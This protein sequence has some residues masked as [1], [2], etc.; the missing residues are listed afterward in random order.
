MEQKVQIESTA[1]GSHTLFVPSLNEHYHS[2]NG[3]KQE[4]E[5]IYINTGLLHSTKEKL[6]LLEIGFG[7]GL[8]AY[9]TLLIT[10]QT[11]KDINYIS[12]E[13]YPLSIDIVKGLNYVENSDSKCKSLYLKLHESEWNCKNEIT[14][15]F[16]LTKIQTDFSQLD[17]PINSDVLFDVIY[18]DAFAPEKQSEMWSQEIFNY[19]YSKTNK[20]G[21]LTTYCAKGV[22]RRMLQQAGYC[23]ERLAGPPGKREILRAVRF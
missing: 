2:V 1:D 7:T 9:L 8:N 16:Y 18:F 4:S 6:N 11:T 5:H 10:E 21:I 14:P 22:V 13:L 23:V 12:L 15:S 20:G 3:A 19:L 17:S